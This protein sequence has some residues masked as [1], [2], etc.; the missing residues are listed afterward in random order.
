MAGFYSAVDISSAELAELYSVTLGTT[1][2][3]AI[4]VTMPDYAPHAG[5]ATSTQ[6]TLAVGV[7]G[8]NR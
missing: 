3:P 7:G 5:P 1:P 6:K 8:L 4:P 2:P